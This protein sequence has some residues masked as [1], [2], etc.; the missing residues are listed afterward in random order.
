MPIKTVKVAVVRNKLFTKIALSLLTI[1]KLLF[2]SLKDELLI[3]YKI[4][5]TP[6]DI[7]KIIKIKTPLEGSEAKAC[8][9][10]NNPDLTIKVPN[11]EK[12]KARI[13]NKIVQFININFFSSILTQ[14]SNAVATNHGIKEAFSTG[15][16]NHQP[17]QPNS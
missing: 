16:Q 11:K 10:V 8:T 9:D 7:P 4:K 3:V 1:S 12:E 6:I 14:C 17:P 5:G 2:S 15:S 13:D